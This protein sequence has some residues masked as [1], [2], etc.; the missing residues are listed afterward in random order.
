MEVW[1]Q[2]TFPYNEHLQTFREVTLSRS[3]IAIPPANMRCRSVLLG[4]LLSISPCIYAFNVARSYR[5]AYAFPSY[6]LFAQHNDG[7][8]SQLL[9]TASH[10]DA[11]CWSSTLDKSPNSYVHPSVQLA[12]RPLSEGG[13]GIIATEDIPANTTVIS[14][15]VDEVPVIDAAVVIE[16]YKKHAN[17]NDE[18]MNMF[19]KLWHG[20]NTLSLTTKRNGEIDVRKDG[21][22]DKSDVLAGILAHLQLV[23]YRDLSP[24]HTVESSFASD[25]SK[26][27][28]AFLDSMPL[29]PRDGLTS[30][31]NPTNFIFW[32]HK[33]I[34]LLKNTIAGE[35]AHREVTHLRN[36]IRE[37]SGVF[38]SEH[39]TLT[40]TDV[41]EAIESAA[42]SLNSRAFGRGDDTGEIGEIK[43]GHFLVP[44]V[45]K[46]NH[47][48]EKYNVNWDSALL[49]EEEEA[50]VRAKGERVLFAVSTEKSVPKGEELLTSYG[51]KV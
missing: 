39:P 11:I 46:M 7:Q 35:L 38:L 30:H 47:D 28:G 24:C 6:L 1:I 37:W 33:E 44:L 29:L 40:L 3:A 9:Q 18:V 51:A 14:L 22:A 10:P 16:R 26:R 27:L 19:V 17:Q 15:A 34:L 8:D 21:I 48:G 50:R 5:N 45:D 2:L 25:E 36:L 13:T 32:K 20:V 23:R 4:L 31:P 49:N 41:I 42:A 12:I 43:D